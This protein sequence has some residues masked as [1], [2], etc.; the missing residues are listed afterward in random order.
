MWWNIRWKSTRDDW[1][2]GP[3]AEVWLCFGPP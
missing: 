3:E 2:G 1:L